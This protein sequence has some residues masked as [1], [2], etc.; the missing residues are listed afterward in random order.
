MHICYTEYSVGARTLVL[1]FP[2]Y[3][4]YSEKLAIEL[5]NMQGGGK[6][7]SPTGTV[8]EGSWHEGKRHGKGR[9]SY[10]VRYSDMCSSPLTREGIVVG[11]RRGAQDEYREGNE[12]SSSICAVHQADTS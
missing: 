6:L 4:I 8:Y 12:G 11:T 3:R 10:K 9:L 1:A 5:T 2:S 7:T